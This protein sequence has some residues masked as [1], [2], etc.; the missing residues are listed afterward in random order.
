MKIP[1][2]RKKKTAEGEDNDAARLRNR[3]AIILLG[4]GEVLLI[5]AYILVLVL[6]RP[7]TGGD[8][9]RYDE[10]LSDA[11]SNRIQSATVLTYDH[12]IV[13]TYDSGDYWTSF[14]GAVEGNPL[15]SQLL[16]GLQAARVPISIDQQWSK[17]LVTPLTVLM[18][19][20]VLVDALVLVFLL[21]RRDT[22]GLQGMGKSRGRHVGSAETKITFGDVAG[23]DE[24]VEE[25][26]EIRDYLSNP[27]RFLAMG[28]RVPSG[29]L[30]VGPPGCGK[31]LLA[32]AVAGEAEV[33]FFSMS[34][35][36]FV[37]IYVGVGAARIRDL[38]RQARAAAPAIIFIDELDA[39]GRGRTTSAVAGQDERE[40]T[41][42][43]LLVGLDGFESET[44]VVVLAATNRPD[45]LDPALLRPGRFDRRIFVEL[46][47][48]NGRIGILKVHTRG[49]PLAEEVNI[50]ALA[51]RTAGFSGADLSSLVNE[52]ALLA[53]RRGV[54]EITHA[55]L[56]EAV[57]RVMAG[58]ERK[59]RL[60]TTRDKELIAYHECGHA[61]VSAV[62]HPADRVTKISIVARGRGG[63]FTWVVAQEE[64]HLAT[65][66][67]LKARLASMMGGRA[68]E[69][70]L[71]G[72]MTTGAQD[73]LE[74]ASELAR[75]MVCELGMSDRLGPM[76]L[77]PSMARLMAEGEGINRSEE[78]AAIVD[79]EIR[80][81]LVSAR[82]IAFTTLEKHRVM[83]D[84]L[85]SRLQEVESL[86]GDELEEMLYPPVELAVTS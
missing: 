74:R 46:P 56:S 41:L 60:L 39:V 36:D 34:G 48:I 52:A 15:F 47:D 5:V 3:R 1:F 65:R 33:P 81:L 13:G 42:N 59:S 58:P 38:F 70:L 29:M 45:V 11:K 23:V 35:S 78:I 83:L 20:L 22:T 6:S 19:A 43:Q 10:L 21:I 82:D 30:L 18:P 14:G 63:G 84:R 68:A 71:S 85:A 72:D 61:L 2:L 77:R 7:V 4:L 86:E 50:E 28:A 55:L 16:G 51:R 64:Q 44:G 17:G 80:D 37:E 31:T 27:G 54:P 79:S 9:L 25:L 73:D 75:K 24:A 12:R 57:E 8:E 40:A 76:S 26:A 69:E 67:Q 32:R 62:L 66:P 53:A 49:K